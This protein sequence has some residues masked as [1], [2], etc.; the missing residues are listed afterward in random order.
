LNFEKPGS[1][2]NG[3]VQTVIPGRLLLIDRP[4]GDIPPGQHWADIGGRRHFTAAFYADLLHHLG[5]RAI[6]ALDP[7]DYD[8]APFLRLGLRVHT[9]ADLGL[10][11]APG[12]HQLG[13][14]LPC[15]VF[16]RFRA[17]VE[18]AGGAI[19]VHCE[20]RPA[21]AN[22]LAA[23]CLMRRHPIFADAEVAAAW[24][25]IV[26]GAPAPVDRAALGAAWDGRWAAAEAAAAL[27]RAAAGAG[28]GPLQQARGLSPHAHGPAAAGSRRFSFGGSDRAGAEVG[29]AAGGR[30]PDRHGSGPSSRSVPACPARAGPASAPAACSDRSSGGGD[31]GSGARRRRRRTD[32]VQRAASTASDGHALPPPLTPPPSTSWVIG[33]GGGAGRA[34]S[35]PSALRVIPPFLPAQDGAG[36]AGI[37]GWDDGRGCAGGL[38]GGGGVSVVG[39]GGGGH[40]TGQ[41][42]RWRCEGSTG[43][44]GGGRVACL[45]PSSP[46]AGSG[47]LAAGRRAPAL[48]AALAILV[49]LAVAVALVVVAAAAAASVNRW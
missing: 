45:A 19:A 20:G 26:R 32:A 46:T 49:P 1:N 37:P 40:G 5:A 29:A 23:G 10:P 25:G 22:T 48:A 31:A 3:A 36:G 9:A 39:A 13:A 47:P 43:A 11:A 35:S 2:I 8:H 15:A 33:G 24:V 12:G 28:A 42:G 4:R 34:R 17:L 16:D 18:A 21:L 6:L 14:P 44:D 27:P 30:C 7:L 41:W 38:R